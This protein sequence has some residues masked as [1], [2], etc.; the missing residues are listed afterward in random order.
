VKTHWGVIAFV[1]AGVVGAV[2]VAANATVTGSTRTAKIKAA[3]IS[4]QYPSTWTAFATTKR[5]RTDQEKALMQKDRRLGERFATEAA[6]SFGWPNLA[7]F[8]AANLALSD[9]V[10]ESVSVIVYKHELFPASLKEFDASTRKDE[11]AG[12]VMS[13]SAVTVG[14]QIAYRSEIE[15]PAQG[16]NDLRLGVL[17]LQRGSDVVSVTAAAD[18]DSGRSVADHILYSVRSR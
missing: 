3:G 5:G 4:L 13:T 7:T 1:F 11:P 12:T 18:S 16:K 2:P 6:A 8:H 10:R 15:S 17:L 9:P 14:D